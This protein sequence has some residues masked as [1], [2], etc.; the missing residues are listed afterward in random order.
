MYYA[1]S[2]EGQN[3]SYDYHISKCIDIFYQEIERNK[4]ALSNIMRDIEYS[5]DAFESNAYLAVSLHDFG[6]LSENFQNEMKNKIFG[7]KLKTINFRHELLSVVYMILAT[8]DYFKK[9]YREFPFHYFAVL[10]HHKSLDINFSSFSNEWNS[11]QPWPLLKQEEYEY[12]LNLSQKYAKKEYGFV[13]NIERF[14]IKKETVFKLLEKYVLESYFVNLNLNKENI[15]TLYS[16]CKGLLQYCDWISSSDKKPMQQ[17]L[18]QDGLKAKIKQKVE[19]DGKQFIER[20]FHK[21]CAI[22]TND[23]VAIAPTGSGKTEAS[24][25]WALKAEKSKVLFLMPTMVTSN[26]IF[27]RLAKHYFS[28]EYC[29]LT[30]SNADVYF[31]INDEF[32]DKERLELLQYKVFI[33]PVMV[34]TIDQMLTSGFNTRYWSLKEYA[35]VGSSVIIDEI[36]AYD[37]FTLALIT[38]TIKKIKKLQGRIMIMSAT[39]PKFLLLHFSELLGIV[40]PIVA[41][42]FMDRKQ[43]KWRFINNKIDDVKDEIRNYANQGKKVA[44]IVNNI[45]TAK[46]LYE[47]LSEKYNTLCLHSEFIMKDRI[48]KEDRLEKDNSYQIVV[49]T[50]VMEVS[51][52]IS[53]NIMFSE[54]APMDSLVQRAGRC[55][56]H[57]EYQDSEF[58]VFDYSEVSEKYVYK[59]HHEVLIKSKEVVKKNQRRLSEREILDMVDEVYEGFDLYDEN[60]KKGQELYNQIIEEEIIFDLDYDEDKLKTRLLDN[61]KVSIIPYEFKEIVE[62]LY[63]KKEYA[64]IALFEVP[65]GISRFN[66]YIRKNYCEN[67]YK[68]PIYTIGHSSSTGLVYNDKTMEML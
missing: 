45:E 39:M 50:Q 16:I 24:L 31:A 2:V 68:L 33:P 36:Q 65:V 53:F 52:D 35:L 19:A 64:K 34:S 66:K 58:I 15:R 29:G 60:Y 9:N 30:H 11:N 63:A 56:R 43:N 40:S 18:T 20:K 59:E 6:K 4:E 22:A 51:L 12:G 13:K 7:S 37:T 5:M 27:N 26:S 57:G 48:E 1:K 32:K 3:G 49:S 10:S 67:N 23:V 28:E 17:V 14:K 54:C 46:R 62:E 44:V 42:E 21:E 47:E 8:Q 25:L 41:S 61:I 38:E 55:N